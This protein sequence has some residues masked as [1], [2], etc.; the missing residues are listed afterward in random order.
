LLLSATA[1]VLNTKSQGQLKKIPSPDD[2]LEMADGRPELD[3]DLGKNKSLRQTVYQEI[4]QLTANSKFNLNLKGLESGL[5]FLSIENKDRK[6]VQ[7][8]II[9]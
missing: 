7:R 5:Y 2:A 4:Q 6:L 9:H 8:L 1:A 3:L